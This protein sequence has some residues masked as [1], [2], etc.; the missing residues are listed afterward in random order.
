MVFYFFWTETTFKYGPFNSKYIQSNFE[1][2]KITQK[3]DQ[4]QATTTTTTHPPNK[5]YGS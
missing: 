1:I 5:G 4:H 3:Y 2:A